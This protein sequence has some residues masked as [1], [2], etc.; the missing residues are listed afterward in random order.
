MLHH[1]VT[2][3]PLDFY[4]YYVREDLLYILQNLSALKDQKI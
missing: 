4:R 1:F 3:E 2:S